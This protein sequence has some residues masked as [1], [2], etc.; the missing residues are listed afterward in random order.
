MNSFI[1]I[2]FQYIRIKLKSDDSYQDKGLSS[3]ERVVEEEISKPDSLSLK[4]S[5]TK[6]A[7]PHFSQLVQSESG[8]KQQSDHHHLTPT[9]SPKPSRSALKNAGSRSPSPATTT[10]AAG[11]SISR[12]SSFCSLFKSKEAASPDSP[13]GQ[14]KKSAIS[15]LL[16]SPRDR[17]RSRSKSRESEKSGCSG[18]LSANTTPSKQRSVLAIFKPRRGSSKSSSP[19]DPEMQE[20]MSKQSEHHSRKQ[21]E[22]PKEQFQQRPGSTTPRLRYYEDPNN[23]SEGIYIPLKGTPPD[24]KENVTFAA[25]I[26][27]A[28]AR[29]IPSTQQHGVTNVDAIEP[30]PIQTITTA[31]A[32]TT[33]TI[34]S[35][36]LPQSSATKST[37]PVNERRAKTITKCVVSTSTT[38]TASAQPK[39]KKSYRIELPDGSIRIPLRSPSDEH[40]PTEAIDDAA[41]NNSQ[42]EKWST[43]AQRNSS[44]DSQDTAVSSKA[45]SLGSGGNGESVQTTKSS[46]IT[47]VATVQAPPITATVVVVAAPATAAVA[48][49]AET[50]PQTPPAKQVSQEETTVVTIE[51]G[52]IRAM[53]KERKRILFST[54]I[55]SG[56][57]EQIFATQLSL[58]KT[59]SLSSQL[60]EQGPNLESP[61]A[62]KPENVPREEQKTQQQS[63]SQSQPQSQTSQSEVIVRMRPKE[64]KEIEVHATKQEA[65]NVNR[66]SM[67][68]E[69]IEEIMETQRRLESERKSSLLSHSAERTSS[70]ESTGAKQS[71]RPTKPER[72]SKN[73]SPKSR[74]STAAAT[75]A[76]ASVSGGAGSSGSEH[77]SEMDSKV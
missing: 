41:D 61:T 67:Y 64:D 33:S 5:A 28:G 75:A 76:T 17:D 42:Q 39:I 34:A 16:D 1:G 6:K 38:P 18:G 40:G 14:R 49:V 12:K 9:A 58:S 54:K 15:I 77:D 72:S 29:H 60:S 43:A 32:A 57:E 22:A 13:S 62:E 37:T 27:T 71:A 50:K 31:A 69:N 56:S 74:E 25:T 11:V 53:S 45:A 48:A 63:L 23:P 66:H 47:T 4:K 7:A 10:T 59:E 65:F 44:Q 68:I 55:G 35:P 3:N 26:A 8:S 73:Q 30:A 2:Y 19:I 24:E 46:V 70:A 21:K 20:I 36:A 51:N 52:G